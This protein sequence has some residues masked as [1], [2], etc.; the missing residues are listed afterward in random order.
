MSSSLSLSRVTKSFGNQRVLNDVSL[1][2]TPG[3]V[4]ALLGRNGA[5][6]STL[7]SILLGL[8]SPDSGTIGELPTVGA[9]LNGPAFYGHLSARNNLLVHTR[10]LGLPAEEADRALAVV[11]LV[12]VGGKKARASRQE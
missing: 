8:S 2:V 1:S 11:G 7:M 9:S 3:R 4:H 10:L 5:G 12:D 6:K